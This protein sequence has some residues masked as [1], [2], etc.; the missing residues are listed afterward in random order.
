MKKLFV[1]A[2]AAVTVFASC[3]KEDN[4]ARTIS[5][6]GAKTTMGLA[7]SF[8]QTR[9][10]DASNA[11]ADEVTVKDVTIFIFNTDGSASTGNGEVRAYADFTPKGNNVYALNENKRISTTAGG[12]HI[13]VGI[14]LP[15]A[16]KGMA[17]EDALK[18]AWQFNMASDLTASTGF[19]MM[20]PVANET[21]AAQEADTTPTANQVTVS[22]E[23]LVSKVGVRQGTGSTG[24]FA[25]AFTITP[26]KFAVGNL[27]TKMFP[28]QQLTG[29]KLMTPMVNST[30]VN[31]L[32]ALNTGSTANK[33]LAVYYVPEHRPASN[34]R[35]EATYA[36]IRGKIAVENFARV[37]AGA[38]VTDVTPGISAGD[39]VF[40]VRAE[41]GDV[42]ICEDLTAA[43]AVQDK[44]T[45]A[46]IYKYIADSNADLYCFYYVFLN[47]DAALNDNQLAVFRNQF[48]D[49]TVGAIKGIGFP[50]DETD[51]SVPEPEI[52]DPE[53]PII[54]T[55]AYLEVIVD[56]APWDYKAI[57]VPLE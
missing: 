3:S 31:A 38:I 21:L 19:A 1:A 49:I 22:V 14:N 34:L 46:N 24:T 43:S 9:A 53:I 27:A 32:V 15:T 5:E 6:E 39:E 4:V 17:S 30:A 33:D 55:D 37:D 48:F 7:I 50:G 45:D 41:A 54:E 28:I 11:T 40:V 23:R 56:V 12:K 25:H 8:P 42:Y 13:Y 18:A 10:A 2:L 20:S 35:G 29:T 36:V 16:L 44:L 57:T 51:P 47:N 52:P 26:D